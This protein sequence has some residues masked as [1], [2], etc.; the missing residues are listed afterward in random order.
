M[1]TGKVSKA[2]KAK[3]ESAKK[4]QVQAAKD[5]VLPTRGLI[6]EGVV[7]SDKMENTVIVQR[8]YY[9]KSKKYERYFRKR[10]R[11]PAHKP[12]EIN[13]KVG[14]KVRIM[15]CRKISKTKNFKVIEKL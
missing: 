6:L 4:T 8:D 10:S 3:A 11:I 5:K 9:D 13:L 7:V 1:A 2:P 12:P 15:E 14:D